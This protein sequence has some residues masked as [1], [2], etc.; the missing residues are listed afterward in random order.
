[1]MNQ[2]FIVLMILCLALS[3]FNLGKIV[4]ATNSSN[5]DAY[6]KHIIHIEGHKVHMD[7]Y[8]NTGNKSRNAYLR[9]L[10]VDTGCYSIIKVNDFT[11]FR[12]KLISL[13]SHSHVTV[14]KIQVNEKTNDEIS[15]AVLR[16]KDE[17]RIR[18]TPYNIKE[19]ENIFSMRK[20][21]VQISGYK[22]TLLEYSMS[23][24]C[25][26]NEDVPN[27]SDNGTSKV[28]H[29]DVRD[30]GGVIAPVMIL[31]AISSETRLVEVCETKLWKE[32]AFNFYVNRVWLE[33]CCS[34][35]ENDLHRAFD[36][37]LKHR[38]NVTDEQSSSTHRLQCHDPN[39]THQVIHVALKVFSVIIVLLCP[40]FVKFIPTKPW[41]TRYNREEWCRHIAKK[42]MDLGVNSTDG[43]VQV[44]TNR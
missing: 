23:I 28:K 29:V 43:I 38:K 1:M 15:L 3:M 37:V 41:H 20:N 12:N 25:L 14:V 10:H 31:G 30:V 35:S 5:S 9:L 40:L 6:Q 26:E 27:S 39:S 22:S 19:L 24:K 32:L 11:P 8:S 2:D 42:E 7:K 17:V 16:T 33:R 4:N 36:S 34:V 44:D 13:L 18:Y 21:T